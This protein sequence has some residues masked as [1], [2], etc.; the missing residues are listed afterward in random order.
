MILIPRLLRAATRSSEL[1]DRTSSCGLTGPDDNDDPR[2]CFSDMH[3]VPRGSGGR[4]TEGR[5]GEGMVSGMALRRE[6]LASLRLI[7]VRVDAPEECIL[8]G[9]KHSW[10][11]TQVRV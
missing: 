9:V 1:L 11:S 8:T 7:Q 3:G 2:R 5:G 10:A 6:V 4:L